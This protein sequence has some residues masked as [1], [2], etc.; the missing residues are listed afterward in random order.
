MFKRPAMYD[1]VLPDSIIF[2]LKND[3]T[4][5]SVVC[6]FDSFVLRRTVPLND[7]NNNNNNNNDFDSRRQHILEE[8]R[9]IERNI[10]EI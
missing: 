4:Y 3:N 6:R 8:E 5:G 7:N 1:S 10:S 9:K 2:V